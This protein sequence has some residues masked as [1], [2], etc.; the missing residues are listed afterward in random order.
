MIAKNLRQKTFTIT[1]LVALG[2]GKK[3][4]TP[5]T[6]VIDQ[7]VG[8]WQSACMKNAASEYEQKSVIFKRE[9]FQFATSTYTDDT[10]SAED[11]TVAGFGTYE[12]KG[13]TATE[14]SGT[15]TNINLKFVTYTWTFVKSPLVAT[16][17]AKACSSTATG[18]VVNIAGKTCDLGGGVSATFNSPAYGALTFENGTL[19]ITDF[20]T[21]GGTEEKR[22]TAVTVGKKLGWTKQPE[23]ETK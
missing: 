2:C 15:L 19:L 5:E 1:A 12:L 11:N 13:S 17:F 10:C 9:T 6:Q 16:D 21:N 3:D 14:K 7:L 20:D 4:D 8:T 22:S 18:G 23:V